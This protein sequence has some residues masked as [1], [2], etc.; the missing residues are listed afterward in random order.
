MSTDRR[1][2]RST[3][4]KLD[5]WTGCTAA[6]CPL[7]LTVHPPILSRETCTP[8][9]LARSG[10]TARFPSCA[11]VGSDSSI[12]GTGCGTEIDRHEA[13]FRTNSPV[14][15][16]YETDVGSR[17]TH[18][19]LNGISFKNGISKHELLVPNPTDLRVAGASRRSFQLRNTTTI[20]M[21]PP[22][23]SGKIRAEVCVWLRR[24]AEMHAAWQE[25]YGM[26]S[27]TVQDMLHKTTVGHWYAAAINQSGSGAGL[28]MSKGLQLLLLAVDLCEVVDVYG[29]QDDKTEQPF[30]YWERRSPQ[31]SGD[32]S[33]AWR[34]IL[35]TEHRLLDQ[36]AAA[37]RRW[38]VCVAV[39]P[40]PT[41]TAAK[42]L[43]GLRLQ[44]ENKSAYHVR[45]K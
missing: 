21:E 4:S 43:P 11:V 28:T 15:S 34:H 17:V 14:L 19:A 16:G 31:L 23:G 20:L 7:L 36:L 32:H 2:R 29:Y 42:R 39:S 10:S 6:A 27:L 22:P 3:W 18:A 9:L 26:R 37:G 30:H 40:H 45:H 38:P 24:S 8:T 35:G 33:F 44:R 12:L 1:C 41:I 5:A 25:T 13:V